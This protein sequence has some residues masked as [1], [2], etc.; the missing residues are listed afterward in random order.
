M[1]KPVNSLV[2]FGQL[3]KWVKN[4]FLSDTSTCL[5]C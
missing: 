2:E 4:H 5:F 1:T 3:Y